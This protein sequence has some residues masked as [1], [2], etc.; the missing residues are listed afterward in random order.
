MPENMLNFQGLPCPEPV[1]RMKRHLEEHSPTHVA[2]IVDNEP[3]REN[4]TRFLSN[5]G[6]VVH[7][8]HDRKKGIWK[9][10]A[11]RIQ[12]EVM[13]SD[14][15]IP[16]FPTSDSST[17]WLPKEMT[18]AAYEPEKKRIAV[19]LT[20]PL[21]GSGDDE[22]GAKLMA[23]F[24]S[25]LPEM[26]DELWRIIMLNGAVRLA[27]KDS[28]VLEKLRALEKKGVSILV[29]GTCLEFFGLTNHKAIGETT[30]MLDVVT[31][32][33]LADSVIRL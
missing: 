14:M 26:G 13:R 20:A 15:D 31:S 2:A 9:L 12:S 32:L 3:C 27:V 4:V 25:T 17:S 18:Q 5:A 19:L 16:P 33:Q 10:D 22:L 30:N 29:C 11:K 21:L 7:S 23:N 24:L 28:P 6:Y 1:I 8:D